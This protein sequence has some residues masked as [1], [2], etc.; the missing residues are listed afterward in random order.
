M[1]A[2]KDVEHPQ[3]RNFAEFPDHNMYRHPWTY[4]RYLDL[5][6]TWVF[7]TTYSRACLRTGP[8]CLL[9]R[10]A[11]NYSTGYAERAVV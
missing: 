11:Y 6:E 1:H 7:R 10:L 2:S 3:P 8:A 4:L 5:I 9:Y